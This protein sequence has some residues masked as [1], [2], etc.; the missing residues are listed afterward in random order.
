ML[1]AE[2]STGELT[3]TQRL[4]SIAAA[5]GGCRALIGD[6]GGGC[7]SYADLAATVR[8]AAAGLAWRGLQP[9]DVVGVYVP[10][11]ISYTLATHAIRAAGGVPS[12]VSA[13]L[14]VPEIAGQLAE[15][16]ARMLLTAPPLAVS[17]LAAADRSWVRQV[18][19][20]G[21]AA[22]T[23]PF[24]ALLG[25]GSLR[26]AITRPHD[27]ALIPFIR[28]PDGMLGPVAVTNR[29]L[30]DELGRLA[31]DT[32][33]TDQ[34]VVIAAPPAGDGRAYSTLLDSALGCGAT[35]VA[36][37]G[38]ELTGAAITYHGTAAIVPFGIDVPL[39]ESLRVF[40]VA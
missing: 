25:M 2:I 16:G 29:E 21:E 35:V 24:A 8:A 4:L 28:R 30:S 38:C 6:Q 40:S 33:L 13:G 10:D 3:V 34:D 18:I 22:G 20:F 37:R 11:A 26:P 1:P 19:S 27:L 12:P 7:Y 23:T 14:A 5:R 9:A 17:A 31:E 39:P 36:A 32:G 15:C